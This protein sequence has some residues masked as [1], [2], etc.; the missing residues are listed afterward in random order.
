MEP[1]LDDVHEM[2]AVA[3]SDIV[4]RRQEEEEKRQKN[5]YY[6]R[7]LPNAPSG[8]ADAKRPKKI[9]GV[10]YYVNSDSSV[11]LTSSEDGENFTVL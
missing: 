11:D 8:K 1:K 6:N 5:V 9:N 3:D 10:Q 7:P 2:Y 4:Q